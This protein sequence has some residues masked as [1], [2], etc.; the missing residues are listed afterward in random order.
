MLTVEL[1]SRTGSP[2][3]LQGLTLAVN[4]FRWHCVGGPKQTTITGSGA[5]E[6]LW[7]AVEWLGFELI[8]RDESQ[9]P[10]WWGQVTR[11]E[12]TSG[13]YTFG[14]DLKTMANRVQVA[15]ENQ[16]A[17]A[18]AV[19]SRATTDWLQHDQ[20]VTTYGQKEALLTLSAASP[21]AAEAYQRSAL[22]LGRLPVPTIALANQG[23]SALTIEAQGWWHTL[24]WRQ[25]I[26]A[27]FG[28]SILEGGTAT[29]YS[30]MNG[31]HGV[32]QRFVALGA[33]PFALS[34][35]A[36]RVQKVGNPPPLVI[37]FEAD[38]GGTIGQI[39]DQV[40]IP[41]AN[42]P[43]AMGWVTA[44]FGSRILLIPGQPYWFTAGTTTM[45]GFD[46]N[47]HYQI[48]H[49][50]ADIALSGSFA[51]YQGGWQY[52][53][54]GEL[55]YRVGGLGQTTDLLASLIA[56]YGQF[57][58][59]GVRVSAPSGVHAAGYS[60]GDNTALQVAEELLSQGSTRSLRL[61]ATVSVGRQVVIS[62]E[63]SSESPTYRIT[64][65]GQLLTR[66]G[67]PLPAGE[68][69]VGQWARLQDVLPSGVNYS[70]IQDPTL[71]FIEEA[72]YIADR[73]RWVLTPRGLP[74]V[75]DL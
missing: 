43:T 39:L 62:D 75:W 6:F 30:V 61:L 9:E 19:G 2:Y 26:S 50:N 36:V 45:A 35:V 17:G 60:D 10:R 13:P 24:D 49:A 34:E 18:S 33:I 37:G 8:I 12:I 57:L 69:P 40:P 23:E 58:T 22:N 63:P 25:A 70:L 48:E 1:Y 7:R 5:E 47:N 67:M 52:N 44:A 15:Y 4:S 14:V 3:R 41:A 66:M 56:T 68:T 31:G 64:R 21:E 55:Y 16:V 32:G 51:R 65:D 71:I 54:P 27:P 20:S 53:Q 46:G 74:T 11:V 72:E 42:V 38:S 73:D 28:S 29:T 59:G